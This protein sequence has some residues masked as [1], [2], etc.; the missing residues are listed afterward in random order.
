[1]ATIKDV[2]KE[3]GVSHGTVSNVLNRHGVVSPEKIK[4]VQEAIEKIGYIPD[5]TAR[6]L[7]TSCSMNVGVILPNIT[8]PNFT[9]IFTG[10]ERVVSVCG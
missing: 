1:M 3:A 2:A 6:S 5:A 4:R 10:I 7:K 8:D 9:Q